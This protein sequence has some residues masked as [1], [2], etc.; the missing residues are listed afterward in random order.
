MQFSVLWMSSSDSFFHVADW[1]SSSDSQWEIGLGVQPV[2]FASSQRREQSDEG[3][4]LYNHVCAT[5]SQF[6]MEVVRAVPPGGNWKDIP[7]S[8][9]SK[10]SRLM[11]IRRS[12]GRTTYY[13]R[14]RWDQPSY[15]INTYFNR[16]GNGAFIHP[17]QDRLISQREAARLQ[18]FPDGYRFLGSTSSI[19]KQ[20][21]NAVPPLLAYAI[22]NQIPKGDVVDL[23]AGAGGL[24]T[25]LAQAG[26]KPVLASDI[27]P[28]MCSTYEHNHNESEVL[29]LDISDQ[30]GLTHLVEAIDVNIAGKTLNLIA[31]GPPCQGFSTA[32]NWNSTDSRNSLVIPFLEIVESILPNY[33][34][35]ENVPGIQWMNSG[36]TLKAIKS[37]LE[38]M[39]YGTFSFLLRAEEYGVPQKRRRV[40]I[41]GS[42]C[43]EDFVIPRPLF[44]HTPRSIGKRQNERGSSELPYPITVSEAISDLPELEQGEGSEVG[45]H[46]EEMCKHS[47]QAYMRGQISWREHLIRRA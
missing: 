45:A 23:F 21:G 18:S 16:P 4:L 39:E 42:R 47:Y 27:N 15:T 35:I 33:V 37:S 36:N 11:Q 34:L 12:G 14:L 2:T 13:G 40:F 1:P 17:A 3:S 22:G 7:L 44:L 9:A 32:G 38:E 25:G 10:S 46:D 24:S 6:D 41:L 29:C 8:I 28:H 31:G 5:L 20:I 43:S 30:Q 19:F 26:H